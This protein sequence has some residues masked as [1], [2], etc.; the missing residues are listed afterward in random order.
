MNTFNEYNITNTKLVAWIDLSTYCNAGCPQCHRTNPNG[1]D[2]VGWLPLVQWSLEQFIEAFSPE[3]MKNIERFEICGTW[4]DPFMAKDIYKIC[5][6]I[7]D[8]SDCWI[9]ANTNGGMRDEEFW[10]DLGVLGQNRM[11]VIFDVEGITQEMHSHYRRKVDLEK[12]KSHI[13]CF[14][15]AGGNAFAHLILFKHNEDYVHEILDMCY[16]ELGMTDHMI[17][18]SNRFHSENKQVF[19]DENGN[20]AVLEEA[21]VKK[22][23]LFN[24]NPVPLRDHEWFEKVGKKNIKRGLWTPKDSIDVDK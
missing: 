2:K 21:T 15:A 11:Q 16:N 14:T 12:L 19:I 22:G 6:Y 18:P 5:E 20:E 9:Q 8:N 13:E 17:Q 23:E 1:L 4:G 10:W 24:N 7:I 3:D